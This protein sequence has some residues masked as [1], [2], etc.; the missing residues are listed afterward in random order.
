MKDFNLYRKYSESPTDSSLY[1]FLVEFVNSHLPRNSRICDVGCGLGNTSRLLI[2]LGYSNIIAIDPSV[3]DPTLDKKYFK[4]ITLK[5]FV[6]QNPDPFD[7][8]LCLNVIEHI[9]NDQEFFTNLTQLLKSNGWLFLATPAHPI[10][11]SYRDELY[12]HYRRYKAKEMQAFFSKDFQNI[13]IYH[14]GRFTFLLAAILLDRLSSVKRK[15]LDKEQ[16]TS[17]SFNFQPPG[18]YNVIK[19]LL[20]LFYPVIY[21]IDLLCK[22]SILGTE[23][24]AFGQK[25]PGLNS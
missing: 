11:F 14:V 19:P 5:E 1:R 6:H 23:I 4:K 2:D 3:D 21:L 8:V 25:I 13:C 16:Q 10:L 12:G 9:Q 20:V 24:I 22:N 17:Q 7:L 15:K 18:I